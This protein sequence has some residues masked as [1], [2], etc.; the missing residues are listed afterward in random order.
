MF[1]AKH[2]YFSLFLPV[3]N[4]LASIDMDRRQIGVI[5]ES[6]AARFLSEKLGMSV[7]SRNYRSKYGEIDLIAIENDETLVFVEVKTSS[8]SPNAGFL[9]EDRIS[10]KKLMR[11]KRMCTLFS[12]KHFQKTGKTYEQRI[13]L[14]AVNILWNK[15]Y[16]I[17]HYK[18]IY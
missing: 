17:R 7:I 4:D 18:N 15:K 14:I 3:S 10:P 9:P 5:G 16:A 2:L 8:G 11:M 1:S 13:D 6:A 12:A